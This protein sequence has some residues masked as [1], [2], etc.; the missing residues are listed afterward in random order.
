MTLWL[1]NIKTCHLSQS[2]R[3]E[4]LKWQK[5]GGGKLKWNICSLFLISA[6]V[7]WL[8]ATL[9]IIA[10]TPETVVDWDELG[11]NHVSVLDVE[12]GNGK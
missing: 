11:M 10:K 8:K 12:E 4:V 9:T 6:G 5:Y 7:S 1:M 3:R 2:W